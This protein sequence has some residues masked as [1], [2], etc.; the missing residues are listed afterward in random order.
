MNNLGIL[1]GRVGLDDG[2][3]ALEKTGSL[4]A[5]KLGTEI[6]VKIGSKINSIQALNDP[7]ATKWQQND[8]IADVVSD[9]INIAVTAATVLGFHCI[10]TP[11]RRNGCGLTDR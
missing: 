6:L 4:M 2:L 1:G 5:R 11:R 10:S 8:A 3:Q 9:S 7:S